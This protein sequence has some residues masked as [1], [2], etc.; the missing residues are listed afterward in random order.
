MRWDCEDSG[1][2][3]KAK[4]PDLA[5]I[6]EML[7]EGW[8]G[9]GIRPSDLDCVIERNGRFL[10]I[11][12]KSKDAGHIKT[13]QRILFERMSVLENFSVILVDGL[14][15]ADDPYRAHA[16]FKKGV[17]GPWRTEGGVGSLKNLVR[18]WAEW[19]DEGL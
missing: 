14:M 5:P 15:T 11:E 6:A 1:C 18:R 4:S 13:G 7:P 12:F 8:R 3:V 19:V 16:I 10:V 17:L 2:L 9:I